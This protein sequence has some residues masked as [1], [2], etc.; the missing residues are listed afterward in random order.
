MYL[1]IKAAHVVAVLIWMAGMFALAHRLADSDDGAP[2]EPFLQLDRN[3]TIWA[4]AL[5]YG[6]GLW[7]ASQARWWMHP[8]FLAKFGLA[9]AMG[10]LHGSLVAA[11]KRRQK[12]ETAR[13]WHRR[14]PLLV[15]ALA[16]AIVVLV[17]VKPAWALGN[18]R[19]QST[20]NPNALARPK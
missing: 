6:V 8:W 3:W 1:W 20:V 14:A 10:G 19:A 12:G 13:S 16:T 4:M 15:V 2:L 18:D 9:V 11:V 17:V 5:A 7:M